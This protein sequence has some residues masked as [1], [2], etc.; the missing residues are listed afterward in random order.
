MTRQLAEITR[1]R[2]GVSLHL[3]SLK[4]LR[5][6]NE[7]EPWE[8]A[9]LE[10]FERGE[11]EHVEFAAD[12]NGLE[13]YRYMAPLHVEESCLPCH[14]KQG[15]LLGQVRGG[16]SIGYPAG[17]L[18]AS[19]RAFR[20]NALMASVVLW[21][22]G[23]GLIAAVATAYHQKSLMVG[24]LRELTLV[25]ELTGLNNRRGFLVLAEKQLQIAQRT[26]RP[27]LLLFVDLDGMKAINDR[28]GHAAGDAALRRVA[29]VLRAAFRSSDILSRFG[30]DEF[31][32]L[33]PDT[34]MDALRRILEELE[35]RVAEANASSADPWRLE[36]SVGAAAFDPR[37]PAS[38][39]QLL[40]EADAAMYQ[41][42]VGKRAGR[43][44]A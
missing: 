1:S 20:R 9:A 16:L 26:S 5:P 14:A 2:R 28:H 4:P 44:T 32:L 23:A 17:L 24:R 21:S 38:L 37:R 3:T 39:D 40:H 10:A 36:V 11:R 25:D 15:Y 12:G 7:P 13:T 27:D 34:G 29:G 35:R 42:K 18:V 30:G 22:L 31:A 41:A 6:G 33:C 19:R 43:P 8:R